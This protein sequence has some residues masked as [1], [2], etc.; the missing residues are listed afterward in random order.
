LDGEFDAASRTVKKIGESSSLSLRPHRGNSGGNGSGSDKGWEKDRTA[1]PLAYAEADVT[2][3]L[4]VA[5]L[6]EFS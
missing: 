4:G 5:A 1:L 6:F 2:D 3:G